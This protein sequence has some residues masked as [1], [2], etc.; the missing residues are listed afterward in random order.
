MTGPMERERLEYTIVLQ[1]GADTEVLGRV[2]DVAIATAAFTAA[3]ARHRRRN[4]E[5]RHGASIVRRHDGE[6]KPEPPRDPALRSWS[7]HLIGRKLQLLGFVEAV[8]QTA[9]IDAA[10][11]TFGLDDDKRRRLAVNPRR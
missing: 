11:T 10:V 9:A 4:L 8:S 5:L 1:D 7:A 3:V 2:A 6:P